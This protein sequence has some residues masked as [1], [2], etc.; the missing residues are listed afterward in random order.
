MGASSTR[1][2]NPGYAADRNVGD[3]GTGSSFWSFT[4][5]LGGGADYWLQLNTSIR[6]LSVSIY[7]CSTGFKEFVVKKTDGNY[8]S[9]YTVGNA[10]ANTGTGGTLNGSFIQEDGRVVIG[11][12]NRRSD[13]EHF[14]NDIALQVEYVFANAPPF[15]T[16][17]NTPFENQTIDAVAF[18]AWNESQ[19]PENQTLQ[20]S[21]EYSQDG[22]ANWMG[23]ANASC[24]AY[25]WNTIEVPEGTAL[26]SVRPFDGYTH[27]ERMQT[28]VNVKHAF[29]SQKNQENAVAGTPVEWTA[30]AWGSGVRQCIYSLPQD[31]L[32]IR[33]LDSQNNPLQIQNDS[34][35]V[36]WQ[37]DFTQGNQ[38]ISFTTPPILL[39][40]TQ[41]VQNH[42][43]Q[44]TFE[45]QFLSS[46][47]LL[48]NPTQND[49]SNASAFFSC[50][51]GFECE[52][53]AVET[54][55]LAPQA[56]ENFSIRAQGDWISETESVE[57]GAHYNK[58]FRIVSQM[59]FENV[60]FQTRLPQGLSYS[61]F[62]KQNGLY[63]KTVVTLELSNGIL[64]IVFPEI[65]QGEF[66][67]VLSALKKGVGESCTQTE[68][69]ETG[70]CENAVCV[71]VEKLMPTALPEVEKEEIEENENALQENYS[72]AEPQE[73]P[74]EKPRATLLKT[75]VLATGKASFPLELLLPAI[76]L[77]AVA[78]SRRFGKNVK[79][80]R[81]AEKGKLEIAVKNDFA[82]LE[83]AC[84]KI[85]TEEN[86]TSSHAPKPKITKTVTGDLLEWNLGV[87]EK[88]TQ[89]RVEC[90]C[91]APTKKAF[92]TAKAEGGKTFQWEG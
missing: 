10:P 64:E 9:V 46:T 80:S 71:G 22:G 38:T 1:G 16:Q 41:F 58:T 67:F 21:L 15:P 61:L 70:E 56:Q 90:E 30:K 75:T 40:Q 66:E 17:F 32:G 25:E 48:Y 6:T 42:S 89:T 4:S 59:A 86:S 51:Q 44:S 39:N 5:A 43:R 12:R 33:V 62:V 18:L 57:E 7:S 49:Y 45:T 28:A 82:R 14:L 83:G 31:Y 50:P 68:E 85:M 34:Q 88:G 54:Q 92:F 73:P 87:L 2:T 23:I 26:I 8:E 47:A 72:S 13:V 24:C 76:A 53:Q 20:Y 69:C 78:A 74:E 52:P 11:V 19:D 35:S 55:N 84:L 27:A 81:K 63:E 65:P 91:N 77:V 37:C 60:S 29:Y 79:V 36:A 3:C